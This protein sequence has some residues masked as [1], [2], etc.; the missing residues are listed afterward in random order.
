MIGLIIKYKGKEYKAGNA[1]EGVYIIST[2]V[3]HRN[4]FIFEGGV[5]ASFQ[6]IRDGIEFEVEIS[7]IKET[8]ISLPISEENDCVEI[9]PEYARMLAERNSE[10]EWN[11]KRRKFYEIRSILMKEGFLSSDE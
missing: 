2:L 8:E 5:V 7:D 6:A 3:L 9:D 10:W 11:E 4:E 1:H